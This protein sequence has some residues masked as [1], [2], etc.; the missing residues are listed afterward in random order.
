MAVQVGHPL[1]FHFLSEIAVTK[2]EDIVGHDNF[3]RFHDCLNRDVL[4]VVGTEILSNGIECLLDWNVRV[5][6]DSIRCEDACICWPCLTS[7]LF[8][9]VEA[10]FEIGADQFC[11]DLE[12]R[13]NPYTH[14]MKS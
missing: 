1:L 2:T 13:V 14:W 3:E 12:F 8:L 10:A 5:H 11:G 7:K 9:E 4:T 6:G